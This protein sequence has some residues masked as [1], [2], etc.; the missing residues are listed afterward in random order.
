MESKWQQQEQRNN[1][2]T[3][4]EEDVN[5]RVT[6]SYEDFVEKQGNIPTKQSTLLIRL[7][8]SAI[9]VLCLAIVL[10]SSS[11]MS[12]KVHSVVQKLFSQ[13]FQF[14]SATKWYEKH[15]GSP[16]TL[17][18]KNKTDIA[19]NSEQNLAVPASG[20]VLQNF[21][22]DGKGVIIQTSQNQKVEAMKEG[23]VLFVGNKDSLGKTIIIQH[24]DGS[25][26]WYGKLKEAKV[27]ASDRVE[28]KQVIGKVST[29]ND[30]KYGSYY[31]AIKMGEHFID[32]K[33]VMSFE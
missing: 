23:V 24:A 16:L 26:S 27:N 2:S 17:F 10:K 8:I 33:K 20:K 12:G 31:F 22:I 13:E 14:A 21:K 25:E 19:R 28:S 30:G 5:E 4:P 6:Y 1:K 11:P 9:I 15:F 32:P 7:L 29:T 3:F 18:Q